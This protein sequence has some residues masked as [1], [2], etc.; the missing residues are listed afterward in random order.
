MPVARD[1][2]SRHAMLPR[3][4]SRE[5]SPRSAMRARFLE[6][7]TNRA[8]ERSPRARATNRQLTEGELTGGRGVIFNWIIS[9]A[10][11]LACHSSAAWRHDDPVSPPLPVPRRSRPSAFPFAI[12]RLRRLV[13]FD[14][15]SWLYGWSVLAAKLAFVNL[16]TVHRDLSRTLS[17]IAR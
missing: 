12:I 16:L 17:N 3:P 13:R 1:I 5:E 2:R 8:S 15:P 10:N 6:I 7:R 11:A 9:N 4:F 14:G